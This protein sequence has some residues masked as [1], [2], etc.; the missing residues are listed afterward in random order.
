MPY[1]HRMNERALNLFPQNGPEDVK[2]DDDPERNDEEEEEER[3]EDDDH[4]SNSFGGAEAAQKRRA[5]GD[6]GD[7][8]AHQRQ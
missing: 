1:H 5:D 8:D 3:G 7:G 6:H 2:S 4:P